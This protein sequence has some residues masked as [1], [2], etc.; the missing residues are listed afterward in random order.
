MSSETEAMVIDLNRIEAVRAVLES[1]C[2]REQFASARNVTVKVGE[3]EA[4]YLLLAAFIEVRLSRMV[5]T[6]DLLDLAEAML[7]VGLGSADGSSLEA[8][9][10]HVGTLLP[11]RSR[12]LLRK[13]VLGVVRENDGASS[14]LWVGKAPMGARRQLYDAGMGENASRL[15]VNHLIS[16]GAI[17]AICRGKC[18]N[19][20]PSRAVV[21]TLARSLAGK[22][23]ITPEM[24]T[25]LI[26]TMDNELPWS[27]DLPLFTIGS[28]CCRRIGTT[29]RSCPLA[30]ICAYFNKVR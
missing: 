6:D 8:S 22:E 15:L 1:L 13:L 28:I 16:I 24:A 30:G 10:D 29:C 19:A 23:E 27:V 18:F 3:A 7:A 17:K 20:N 9:I 21:R 5:D 2:T 4:N 12:L 11:A 25:T 14:A 26:K